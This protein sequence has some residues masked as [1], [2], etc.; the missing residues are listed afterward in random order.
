MFEKEKTRIGYTKKKT[1]AYDLGEYVYC[2]RLE[3]VCLTHL[4][5][6]VCVDQEILQQDTPFHK[7]LN[8]KADSNK[9]QNPEKIDYRTL[10]CPKRSQ[11]NKN[12]EEIRQ[13][14]GYPSPQLLEIVFRLNRFVVKGS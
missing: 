6:V 5:E 3:P 1:E 8:H 2:A 12:L 10:R 13:H 7:L 11:G 14:I 9:K 4:L